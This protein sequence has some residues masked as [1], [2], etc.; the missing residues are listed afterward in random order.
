MAC[1]NQHTTHCLWPQATFERGGHCTGCPSTT[2]RTCIAL[3]GRRNSSAGSG[4]H[5]HEFM[6]DIEGLGGP[7]PCASA[8]HKAGPSKSKAAAPTGPVPQVALKEGACSLQ[9]VLPDHADDLVRAF[10]EVTTDAL[11]G[12]IAVVACHTAWG[13]QELTAD[14][15]AHQLSIHGRDTYVAASEVGYCSLGESWQSA[16]HALHMSESRSAAGTS[17][18]RGRAGA[19]PSVSDGGDRRDADDRSEAKLVLGC[20]ERIFSVTLSGKPGAP[21]PSSAAKL[22]VYVWHASQV[23]EQARQAAYAAQSRLSFELKN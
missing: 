22:H 13:T 20:F 4:T 5:V 8:R 3:G 7:R 23:G 21:P 16:Q 11:T 19:Q 10:V 15:I 9:S 2:A 6:A 17:V 1:N 18:A 14:E 12:R